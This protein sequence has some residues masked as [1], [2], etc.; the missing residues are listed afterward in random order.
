M[1][2]QQRLQVELAA[3]AAGQSAGDSGYSV[4]VDGALFEQSRDLPD[5]GAA[6]VANDFI[7]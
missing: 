4:H 2:V 6:A 7:F 1:A 3:A 5:C